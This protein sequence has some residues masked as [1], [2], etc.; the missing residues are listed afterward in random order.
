MEAGSHVMGGLGSQ[1]L[2]QSLQ[3]H[4]TF[5]GIHGGGAGLPG[6]GVLQVF[7]PHRKQ[8]GAALFLL[9]LLLFE[10]KKKKKKN[11]NKTRQNPN[12]IHFLLTG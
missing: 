10:R 8:H 2:G 4:P 11:Q 6:G 3:I 7:I 12:E 1:A 5:K 9:L